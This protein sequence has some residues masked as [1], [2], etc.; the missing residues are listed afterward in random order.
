MMGNEEL[1]LVPMQSHIH[2]MSST[3]KSARHLRTVIG[4]F[5][6]ADSHGGRSAIRAMF[7]H[8]H[9][10]ANDRPTSLTEREM[11]R[12]HVE[13]IVVSQKLTNTA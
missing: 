9:Q 6:P 2:S 4:T 13:G 3:H 8:S 5:I 7:E 12:A 10:I 1:T 11:N